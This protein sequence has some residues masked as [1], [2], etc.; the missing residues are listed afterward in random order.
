MGTLD[1]T[2]YP[3]IGSAHRGCAATADGGAIDVVLFSWWVDL[4][5]SGWAG[6]VFG[7]WLAAIALPLALLAVVV[8]VDEVK[9]A[10]R[11]IRRSVLIGR[12]PSRAAATPPREA[13]P[14]APSSVAVNLRDA[15]PVKAA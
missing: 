13:A 15:A 3:G 6:A 5:Q 10:V 1:G 9:A 8:A 7:V 11:A 4:V 14:P 2:W 12:G